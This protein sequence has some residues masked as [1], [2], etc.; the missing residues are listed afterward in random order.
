LFIS[1]HTITSN[2]IGMKN[3]I[4]AILISILFLTSC[5]PDKEKQMEQWKTEIRQTEQ[6][7]AEMAQKEGIPKAFLTY[8]ADDAVLLRNNQLIKGEQALKAFYSQQTTPSEK[9]NLT[10]K[11]DFVDVSKSGDL[12]YTYGSYQYTVTDSLGNTKTSEGIFHTVWK[13]QSDGSW[14]FVWD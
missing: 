12:G 5:K 7:F 13:R 3:L 1:R 6:A 10:W 14:R 9:V 2:K 11:P 4:P 8:A